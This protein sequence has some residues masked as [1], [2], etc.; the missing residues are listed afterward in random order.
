LRDGLDGR[1]EL[2]D[3]SRILL[4]VYAVELELLGDLVHLADFS[5]EIE[6][7]RRG[8]TKHAGGVDPLLH[9]RKIRELPR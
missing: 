3:S 7:I 1:Q 8:T 5:A 6:T 9:R 2:V 4:R